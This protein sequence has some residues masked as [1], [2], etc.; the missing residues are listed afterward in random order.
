MERTGCLSGWRKLGGFSGLR[1]LE[2]GERSIDKASGQR[3]RGI[4]FAQRA[5]LFGG[6]KTSVKIGEKIARVEIGIA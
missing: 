4:K 5:A 3:R 1:R 2:M 6:K